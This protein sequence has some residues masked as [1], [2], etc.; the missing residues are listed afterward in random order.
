VSNQSYS[1]AAS[2]GTGGVAVTGPDGSTDRRTGRTEADTWSWWRWGPWLG[3]AFVAL[4]GAAVAWV[5]FGGDRGFAELPCRSTPS[6]SRVGC[7]ASMPVR[8]IVVRITNTVSLTP[9]GNMLLLGGEPRSSGTDAHRAPVVLAA[10]S[11]VEKREAWRVPLDE[12]DTNIVNVAV[13][14]DGTKAAVWGRPLISIRAVPGGAKLADISIETPFTEPYYD[15][16]FSDDGATVT[17]GDAGRRRTYQVAAPGAEPVLA[18]GFATDGKCWGFVGQSNTWSVR[19]RD[20]RAVVLLLSNLLAQLRVGEFS[21]SRRL[22]E[23]VCG[24]SSVALLDSPEG[25]STHFASFSP[26]N[27]RLAIVHGA[28]FGGKGRTLIE[29][30]DS[31]QSL[32]RVAAF[33]I[34]GRVGYRIGWSQ[35]ARRF[36]AI[37]SVDDHDDAMIF[38]LP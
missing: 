3:L 21:E 36:A 23:V 34:R 11:I 16:A 14:A 38:A 37:R 9:D 20:G 30:W 33:P 13:A 19:S 18:S 26:R 24:T 8:D 35:D 2:Q 15:V 31:G 12:Y 5:S 25:W 28:Y 17:T 29:I 22:S 32:K 4:A 7:I 6:E 1:V 10:L 27:D